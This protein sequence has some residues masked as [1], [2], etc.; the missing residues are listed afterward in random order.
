[1]QYGIKIF[2][3]NWHLKSDINESK[4]TKHEHTINKKLYLFD[5]EVN[6]IKGFPILADA[7]AS[8]I[9]E[10]NKKYTR[11]PDSWNILK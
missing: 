1:M 5:D 11:K 10:N 6:T 7:D 3:A 9:L 4:N 8:F 2:E